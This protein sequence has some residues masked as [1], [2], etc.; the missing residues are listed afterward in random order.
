[1]FEDACP[2]ASASVV[3]VRCLVPEAW[4]DFFCL[5]ALTGSTFSVVRTSR[6]DLLDLVMTSMAGPIGMVKWVLGGMWM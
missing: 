4:P 6:F 1:M 2:D 5:D 3:T